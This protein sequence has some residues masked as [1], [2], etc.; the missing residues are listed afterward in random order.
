MSLGVY[1]TKYGQIKVVNFFVDIQ[2]NAYHRAIK[3]KLIDVKTSTYNDLDGQPNIKDFKFKV[4][5]YLRISKY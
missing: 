5:D 1:H 2:N 4:D 3:V